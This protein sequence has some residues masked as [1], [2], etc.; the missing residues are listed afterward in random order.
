MQGGYALGLK[1]NKAI[2]HFQWELLEYQQD[3]VKQIRLA[4]Y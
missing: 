1:A 2:E 4:A 3:I